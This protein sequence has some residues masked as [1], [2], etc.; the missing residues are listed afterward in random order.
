MNI[1][2]ERTRARAGAGATGAGTFYSELE[3]KPEPP[4]HFGRG[5]RG[6]WTGAVKQDGSSSKKS[7]G[8]IVSWAV[9]QNYS[10]R[11]VGEDMRFRSR[12][13]HFAQGWS[14]SRNRLDILIGACVPGARIPSRSRQL[15]PE[16]SK[17][18]R[19]LIPANI[20]P[21]ALAD[22]GGNPTMSPPKPRKGAPCQGLL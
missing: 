6:S 5:R 10:I 20:H 17:I 8:K 3:P 1:L 14:R 9:G 12:W 13:V 22:P 11:P 7:V 19:L 15:E 18:S 16:L 2:S 21:D 4:E